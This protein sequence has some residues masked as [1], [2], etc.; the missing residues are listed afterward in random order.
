MSLTNA[1]AP[2]LVPVLAMPFGALLSCA[3]IGLGIY[4]AWGRLK[5]TK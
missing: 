3:A 5:H 4:L 1:P 2:D